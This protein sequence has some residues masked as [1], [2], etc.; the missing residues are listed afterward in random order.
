MKSTK[1]ADKMCLLSRVS[2]MEW[3][4]KAT[5]CLVDL[6]LR[7]PASSSSRMLLIKRI[8]DLHQ[9]E[10]NFLLKS[11][12]IESKVMEPK[13]MRNS[14]D[15]PSS[16]GDLRVLRHLTV[17]P[18]SIDLIGSLKIVMSFSSGTSAFTLYSTLEGVE[19]RTLQQL[20]GDLNPDLQAS[21]TYNYPSG[22]T[23]SKSG[24]VL[25]PL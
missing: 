17:L 8:V 9:W 18:D 4:R 19:R 1:T 14:E 12:K 3:L 13:C 7:N 15:M 16:P 22:V 11:P 21:G 10:T 6:N 25:V 2:L 24:L 20:G 23:R 5:G